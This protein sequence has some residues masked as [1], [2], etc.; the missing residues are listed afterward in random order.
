MFE[1]ALD[2]VEK[3]LATDAIVLVRGRVDHKEAGKSCV[4]VQD[5]ER[6]DPSDA[7]IEKAKEQVAQLAATMAPEPIR[8]RV[9]ATR[10][11]P[12]VIGEL[13]DLFERY[14]GE[15]EFVLEMDTRSGLRCLRFGDG[16]KIAAR[17]A[18]LRAELRDLLGPGRSAPRR[19]RC[20][21]RV[22]VVGPGA[23][24]ATVAAAVRRAGAELLLCGRTP[25][26]RLVVE[27]EGGGTEIVPGP[28][29]TDPA[30]GALARRRRAA[31]PSR[32]TRPRA[33]R[34]S[35]A[36]C[37]ATGTVV[38]VLQ[39]GVEQRELV[40]PHAPGAT[41]LPAVVWVPAEAVAPGHV[42]VRG[43]AAAHAARRARRP[44][45]RGG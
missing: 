18:G 25:H 33:R 39:N 34:R 42:R 27:H 23:I 32:R 22:A 12:T 16:Y 24:G 35:C 36:R 2:A 29:L 38:V 13:R 8:L 6:F 41:V 5:A 44:R 19:R 17:D 28:V 37:A 7:E 11:Q 10:L 40:G 9:D 20:V 31:S 21:T 43:D 14:P 1:K 45:D 3:L 26:E 15:A 30:D 4:I